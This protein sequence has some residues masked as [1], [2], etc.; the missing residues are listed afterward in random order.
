MRYVVW[1]MQMWVGGSVAI[2]SPHRW[3]TLD[4]HSV[5]TSV[6]NPIRICILSPHRWPTL[7]R[8]ALSRHI[9]GQPYIG[10]RSPHR[11]PTLDLH[12]LPTTATPKTAMADTPGTTTT[13]SATAMRCFFTQYLVHAAKGAAA[14]VHRLAHT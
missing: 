13:T 6:A 7:L 2:L 8:S 12:Y 14:M 9:G 3:P 1:N 11:W 10:I 4:L 5:A